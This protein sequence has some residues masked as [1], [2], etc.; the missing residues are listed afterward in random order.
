MQ[1]KTYVYLMMFPE[2][3]FKKIWYNPQPPGTFFKERIPHLDNKERKNPIFTPLFKDKQCPRQ[4]G[5]TKCQL[6]ISDL[7]IN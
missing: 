5:S 3:Y 4:K 1:P 6:S 2:I 7:M